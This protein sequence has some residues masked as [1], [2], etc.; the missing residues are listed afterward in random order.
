[1]WENLQVTNLTLIDRLIEEARRLGG[2]ETKTEAVSAA[3]AEYVKRHKQ[4]RILAAFG[5]VD[6]DAN[7]NYKLERQRK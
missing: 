4:L 5:T 2:H 1:M 6:V 3:L 7:Y